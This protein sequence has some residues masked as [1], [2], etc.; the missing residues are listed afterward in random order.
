M[1]SYLYAQGINKDKGKI[2]WPLKKG[3][4]TIPK[5]FLDKCRQS[6][7]LLCHQGLHAPLRKKE[8][9][10]KNNFAVRYIRHGKIQV[11][12]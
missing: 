4:Q 1:A 2:L 9:S 3:T 6:L 7:C 12:K 5:W 11:K 8:L 10:S